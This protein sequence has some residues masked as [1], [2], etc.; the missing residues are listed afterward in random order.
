MYNKDYLEYDEFGLK[1]VNCMRCNIPVKVRK[2]VDGILAMSTMSH[3]AP[4]PFTLSDGSYTNILMCEDC[5]KKYDETEIKEME[6]QFHKGYE[7]EAIGE[8]RSK[9]E[10]DFIKGKMKKLKFVKSHSFGG[11]GK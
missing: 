1:Q 6:K 10:V 8:K 2:A 4:V 5:R 9:K 7:L 11:M 3:F